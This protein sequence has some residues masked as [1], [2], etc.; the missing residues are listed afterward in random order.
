MMSG[1]VMDESVRCSVSSLSCILTQ[2]LKV[3]RSLVLAYV[4]PDTADNQ[5]VRQCL[6]YFLPVY[7]YSSSENQRRMK[8]VRPAVLSSLCVIVDYDGR[9]FCLLSK[10]FPICTRNL[11]RTKR[12]SHQLK[13]LCYSSTGQIH[14]RRSTFSS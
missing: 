8:T 11:M 14:R 2:L 5:E 1:M 12:W 7:C 9:S 6:S 13:R 4:S 10:K 3:L